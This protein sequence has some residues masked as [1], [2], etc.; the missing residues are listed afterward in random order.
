MEKM[1]E[2]MEVME[3]KN[4]KMWG[5]TENRKNDKDLTTFSAWL[6]LSLII[7]FLVLFLFF[8]CFPFAILSIIFIV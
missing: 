6:V 1:E 5:R 4:K 2:K 3:E 7:H 8:C